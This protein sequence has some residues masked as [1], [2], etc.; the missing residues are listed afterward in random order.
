MICLGDTSYI[1]CVIEYATIQFYIQLDKELPHIYPRI[2]D[3]TVY[4]VFITDNNC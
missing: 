4:T 2:G 3:V 1:N